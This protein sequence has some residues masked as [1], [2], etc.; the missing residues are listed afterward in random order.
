MDGEDKLE[1]SVGNKVL[2]RVKEERNIQ[3]TVQRRKAKWTGQMLRRCC[4]LKHV[5]DVKI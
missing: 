4:L 3:S 5:I 2:Q 1:D